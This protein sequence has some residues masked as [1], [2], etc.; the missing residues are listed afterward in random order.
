MSRQ[1]GW[2]AVPLCIR[3]LLH[4][5][6]DQS[7]CEQRRIGIGCTRGW[8]KVASGIFMVVV[9]MLCLET[10]R[11]L[12]GLGTSGGQILCLT[13]GVSFLTSEWARL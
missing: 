7:V 11:F 12:S 10:P 2:G 4:S 6:G 13:S 5:Y 1:L 9:G 3:D 8:R